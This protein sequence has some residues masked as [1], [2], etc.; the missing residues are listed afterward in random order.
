MNKKLLFVVNPYSGR[1][2]IKHKLLGILDVFTKAGYDTEVYITQAPKDSTRLISAR[3]SE[4]DRIIVSGGDGS[5]NEGVAGILGIEGEKRPTLGYIP[6]GTT[7]DYAKSLK[8][9]KDMI[10]AAQI[11]ANDSG[12]GTDVGRFC[13]KYFTY[14]AGFGAFTEVSYMTPQESKNI[15]GQP[16]YIFEGIKRLSEL[17]PR[18]VRLC[19]ENKVI[20]EEFLLCLVTNSISVAGMK[21]IADK[22]VELDDGLFE[23][24]LVKNPQNPIDLTMVVSELL[25]NE[26]KNQFVYRF[27]TDRLQVSS[28]EPIDWVLDGEF[29]GKRTEVEISVCKNV[30][31][32][33]R[34]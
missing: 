22:N 26:E 20:E 11:A 34:K 19:Y 2:Q 25:Q 10:N 14:V 21:A 23:V 8:L 24:V 33:V 18:Q 7:N 9:P 16:A 5:L 29:G 17:K 27:K 6:A 15:F 1:G 3:G 32:M 4:F 28:K 12:L 13:D 30:L 31:N